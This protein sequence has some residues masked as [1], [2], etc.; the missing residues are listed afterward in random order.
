MDDYLLK[1]QIRNL[2]EA[3]RFKELNIE[4]LDTLV[5]LTRWFKD[6]ADKHN[7]ELPEGEALEILSRRALNLIRE[8]DSPQ[9]SSFVVGKKIKTRRDLTDP[10]DRH[11]LDSIDLGKK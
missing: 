5:V 9:E 1:E 10:D 11:Q 4:L 7:V 8:I 2:Q 6:F 3:V